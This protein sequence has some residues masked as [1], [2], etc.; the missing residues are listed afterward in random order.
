MTLLRGVQTVGVPLHFGR[1]QVG[2]V[3]GAGA[4]ET[5]TGLVSRQLPAARCAGRERA[6][7]SFKRGW[8]EPW[9]FR[10]RLGRQSEHAA[11][12]IANPPAQPRAQHTMRAR[13]SW[14][15]PPESSF[16]LRWASVSFVVQGCEGA[17]VRPA[18]RPQ[19]CMIACATAA[20]G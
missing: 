19:Q 14:A 5:G 12:S 3:P 1:R 20:R 9:A 17:G 7:R 6:R 11:A 15:Q 2:A 18:A 8:M 16:R 10:R 13:R 4:S